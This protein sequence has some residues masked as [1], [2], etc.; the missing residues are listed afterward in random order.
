MIEAKG[1]KLPHIAIYWLEDADT[2]GH[3][4]N[5]T[6]TLTPVTRLV[7]R[8]TAAVI[9]LTHT[10]SS[11]I[12]G[13]FYCCCYD[14][15]YLAAAFDC[16]CRNGAVKVRSCLA[17]LNTKPPLLLSLLI[18]MPDI[19]LGQFTFTKPNSGPQLLQCTC[20]LY[21]NHILKL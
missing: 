7:V 17:S 4:T 14:E 5:S 18:I 19:A 12:P 20:L 2:P 16:Y 9:L 21:E 3:K 6:I 1:H 15:G 11:R 13:L 10:I 8:R